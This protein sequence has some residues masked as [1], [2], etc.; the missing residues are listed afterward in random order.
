MISSMLGSSEQ[1]IPR[2]RLN[3]GFVVVFETDTVSRHF[4]SSMMRFDKSSSDLANT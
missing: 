4:E 1:Q 3:S 2:C